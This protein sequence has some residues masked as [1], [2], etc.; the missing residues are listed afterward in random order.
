MIASFILK[1]RGESLGENTALA[2][3]TVV[4]PRKDVVGNAPICGIATCIKCGLTAGSPPGTPPCATIYAC[5][6]SYP[7]CLKFNLTPS[8]AAAVF[9]QQFS[10][11]ASGGS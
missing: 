10:L 7:Q 6:S 2:L 9:I 8:A 11:T 5:P 1:F 3:P 4:H